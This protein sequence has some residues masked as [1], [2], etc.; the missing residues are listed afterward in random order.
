MGTARCGPA[1]RLFA[2]RCTT[3]TASAHPDDPSLTASAHPDAQPQPPLPTPMHNLGAPLPTPMHHAHRLSPPRC[4]TPTA[5]PHPDAQQKSPLPTTTICTPKDVMNH[6]PKGGPQVPMFI[7][8]LQPPSV[9]PYG[10]PSPHASMHH[11]SNELGMKMVKIDLEVDLD[12]KTMPRSTSRS[13]HASYT[14]PG[15]TL[16]SMLDELLT[17]IT[18]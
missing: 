18:P 5:S 16:R 9:G 4:T 3:P 12:H 7:A 6:K 10:S 8:T 1:N 15:S 13:I 17:Q 11:Q 14:T 2:P